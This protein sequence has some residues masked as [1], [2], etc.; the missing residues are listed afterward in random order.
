MVAGFPTDLAQ[1]Q[2]EPL[3]CINFRLYF[4]GEVSRTDNV[5][6]MEGG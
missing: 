6:P 3:A 2:R 5:S 4:L 1:V